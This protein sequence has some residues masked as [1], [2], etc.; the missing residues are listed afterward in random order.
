MEGFWDDQNRAQKIL[1]ERTSAQ[2]TIDSFAKMTQEIV[3]MEELLEMAVEESDEE[4][5]EEVASE[6]PGMTKVIRELELK[7][8]LS[9][10]EDGSDAIVQIHPGAGG[11]DAMDWAE[12][13]LRM[14]LRWCESKGLKVEMVD[15]QPGAAVGCD[16]G[17]RDGLTKPALNL[18]VDGHKIS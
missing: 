4:T 7:R 2:E 14:Y 11:V 16:Q 5:L 9:G 6:I 3:A 17:G 13:L 12:M 10:A 1:R 15:H 18:L 8:M